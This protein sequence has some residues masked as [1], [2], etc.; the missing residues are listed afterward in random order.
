[1]ERASS[2]EIIIIIIIIIIITIIIINCNWVISRWLWLY[3][4]YTNMEKK[5][6]RKFKSGGLLER[7]VVASNTT[8]CHSQCMVNC[9]LVGYDIVYWY[10]NTV[11]RNVQPP[12]SEFVKCKL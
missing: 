9:S 4:M 5:V 10:L 8:V 2:S 3:Y 7:H 6:T 12:T 11:P 1:M